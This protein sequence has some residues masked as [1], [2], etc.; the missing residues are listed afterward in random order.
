MVEFKYEN[1]VFVISGFN[2]YTIDYIEKIDGESI[3]ITNENIYLEDI[4]PK[5]NSE[6]Y[7][8]RLFNEDHFLIGK[9]RLY[10][11]TEGPNKDKY[12]FKFYEN[13][14]FMYFET[15]KD[16]DSKLKKDYNNY[17][18]IND[19]ILKYVLDNCIDYNNHLFSKMEIKQLQYFRINKNK[20]IDYDDYRGKKY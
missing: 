15:K 14:N 18:I 8:Y 19:E 6:H 12:A 2:S 20:E 11:V 16:M 17:K 10:K 1:K 9:R 5:R 4:K 13:E 7:S 3:E